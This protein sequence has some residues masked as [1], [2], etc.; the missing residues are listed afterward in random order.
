[1]YE[2][3]APRVF[4]AA[5][6]GSNYFAYS[7]VIAR[8]VIVYAT[9]FCTG[10]NFTDR[11]IKPL[12]E[13]HFVI[14]TIFSKSLLY[15][16]YNTNSAHILSFNY[17][18]CPIHANSKPYTINPYIIGLRMLFIRCNF[19]CS[20]SFNSG[21]ANHLSILVHICSSC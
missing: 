11:Y 3:A 4:D 18:V 14:D 2:I 15:Y 6:K 16:C 13:C 20:I 21:K 17:K 9:L 1:M 7:K 19:Y 5:C 12:G 8:L 10:D